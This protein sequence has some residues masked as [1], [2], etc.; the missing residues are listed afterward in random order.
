[1]SFSL[2]KKFL[3][4][5]KMRGGGFLVGGACVLLL[6]MIAWITSE[7]VRTAEAVVLELIEQMERLEIVAARLEYVDPST[8]AL[9]PDPE[10]LYGWKVV[11]SRPGS[12]KYASSDPLKE[13]ERARAAWLALL[14]ES[15]DLPSF[16]QHLFQWNTSADQMD[17]IIDLRQWFFGIASV[18]DANAQYF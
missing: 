17:R 7:P 18:G 5:L 3:L 12:S 11:Q 4:Q 13:Q 14:D 2:N 10:T 6:L 1:M 9:P 16:A 8:I 15:K